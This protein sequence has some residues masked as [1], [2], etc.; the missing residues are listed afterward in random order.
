MP[1]GEPD[2]ERAETPRILRAAVHEVGRSLLE[3]VVRRVIREGGAK[4]LRVPD[5]RATRLEGGIQPLVRIDGHRVCFGKAPKSVRTLGHSCRKPTVGPVNVE[6]DA[7][8]PTE[9]RDLRQRIHGASA[10]RSGRAHHDERDVPARQI[11]LNRLPQRGHIHPEI[12]VAGN[13]PDRLR[14]EASEVGRLLNPGVRLARRIGGQRS[15]VSGA[16]ALRPHVPRRARS[17]RGK[18]AHEVRH[19][20]AADE[21]PAAARGKT[22]ELGKPAHRLLLD[23]RRGRRERPRADIGIQG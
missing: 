18:E 19:V 12:S 23:L 20:P 6:P 8:L 22:D 7:P 13:P 4:P 10:D 14:P 15:P 21:Q 2:L 16:N 3:V 17:A 11:G 1:E 9:R 5:Q